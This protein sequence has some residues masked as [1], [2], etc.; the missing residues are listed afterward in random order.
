MVNQKTSQD[1]DR[2]NL[3]DKSGV[4]W[5][6]TFNGLRSTMEKVLQ[7]SVEQAVQYSPA[8]IE[9]LKLIVRHPR[10]LGFFLESKSQWAMRRMLGAASNWAE[11]FTI[12]MG[13]RVVKLGEDIIEVRMPGYW[14]NQGEFGQIH[15]GAL[16]SI[17]EFA[18]RLFWE[19]HLDLK[20]SEAESIRVQVRVLNRPFGELSAVFRLPV[21][22]RETMLLRLRSEGRTEVETQ[23]SIYDL[24]GRLVAECEVDWKL[25][26]NLRIG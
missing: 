20:N 21:A 24:N 2:A 4:G 5:K 10:T 26:R 19:Y 13:F 8:L 23:I 17:G 22:D 25:V 12:G 18:A 11:P 1:A 3:T 9:E 15:S 16:A 7:N 6:L 14:R